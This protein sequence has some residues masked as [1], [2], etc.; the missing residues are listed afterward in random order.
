MANDEVKQDILRELNEKWDNITE[1][2]YVFISALEKINLEELR[3][4]IL[5]KVREIYAVRYPY[6][7][8]LY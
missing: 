3:N 8:L 5:K 4:I 7:T 1:G 6:K 2:N